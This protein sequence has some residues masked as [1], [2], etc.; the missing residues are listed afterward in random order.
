MESNQNRGMGPI[1]EDGHPELAHAIEGERRRV[2]A[3][4][5]WL[6]SAMALVGAGMAAI[7][8]LAILLAA[9]RA[10]L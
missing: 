5:N 7:I 10:L 8:G 4:R 2:I 9:L 1:A 3:S 6:E